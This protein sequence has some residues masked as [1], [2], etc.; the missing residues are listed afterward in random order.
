MCKKRSCYGV[1]GAMKNKW[2]IALP[3]MLAACGGDK[4]A[5]ICP[6]VAAVRD[7]A[8]VVDF[9]RDDT[10]GFSRLVAA[11]K[12]GSIEGDCAFRRTSIDVDAEL[13]LTARRGPGLGGDRVEF[14]YFVAVV[15]PGDTPVSKQSLTAVF[16]FGAQDVE[17]E[18]VEKIHIVI[19]TSGQSDAD[20]R[21]LAGFQLSP[22]QLAYNRNET[23]P[24][25]TDKRT[26]AP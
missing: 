23:A 1:W 11:G 24:I 10:P 16:R 20:W 8:Q 17:A 7:L 9:G 3:L 12:I 14:P 5:R 19:P 18:S 15:G 21:V 25:A 4:S 13:H 26:R 6:Q 22:E 2:L